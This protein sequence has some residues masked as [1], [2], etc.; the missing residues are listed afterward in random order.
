M[1]AFAIDVIE[2]NLLQKVRTGP[3]KTSVIQVVGRAS[4]SHQVPW[5]QFVV[6]RSGMQ[7]DSVCRD[8]KKVGCGCCVANFG[9]SV[10][11]QLRPSMLIRSVG[12]GFSERC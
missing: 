1:A 11:S 8:P 12:S 9:Q 7:V 4:Q 10:D 3:L 2:I 5:D 6:G